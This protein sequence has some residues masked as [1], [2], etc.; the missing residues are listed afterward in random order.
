MASVAASIGIPDERFTAK[1]MA[2]NYLRHYRTVLKQSRNG[3]VETAQQYSNRKPE[4]LD[5]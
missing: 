3:K 2:G 4:P 1:R 5:P